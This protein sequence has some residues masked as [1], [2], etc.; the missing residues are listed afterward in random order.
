MK[1]LAVFLVSCVLALS[2][3]PVSS[4]GADVTYKAI[5]AKV[6]Q[7]ATIVEDNV[8]FTKEYG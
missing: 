8:K 1:K 7:D 4:F 3:I 5:D 2:L 6:R